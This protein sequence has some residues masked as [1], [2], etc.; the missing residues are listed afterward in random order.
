MSWL[1]MCVF[2]IEI[3]ELH[4]YSDLKYLRTE[5]KLQYF[6]KRVKSY[7]II[8]LLVLGKTWNSP[9]KNMQFTKYVGCW[10]DCHLCSLKWTPWPWVAPVPNSPAPAGACSRAGRFA[11]LYLYNCTVII[12]CEKKRDTANT[13]PESTEPETTL[14]YIQSWSLICFWL[15]R[16]QYHLPFTCADMCILWKTLQVCLQQEISTLG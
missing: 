13:E 15:V 2:F 9:A 6:K 11:H 10:V 12:I 4:L 3:E 14:I 16:G 5:Q 7:I 1:A 8:S